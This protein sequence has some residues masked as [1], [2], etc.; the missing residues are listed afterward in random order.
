M[1]WFAGACA[2]IR[3]T[4]PSFYA[5]LFAKPTGSTPRQLVWRPGAPGVRPPR[6]PIAPDDADV[7]PRGRAS[8]REISESSHEHPSYACVPGPD[9]GP[10]RPIPVTSL[11]RATASSR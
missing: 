3:M 8:H 6:S 9:R 4:R 10:R 1:A 5:T 11:G 7:R 2:T